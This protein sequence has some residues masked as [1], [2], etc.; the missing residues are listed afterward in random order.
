MD[1][2]L[3]AQEL[4]QAAARGDSEAVRRLLESGADP[5]A[6]NAFGRTPIQV[7]MMGNPQVAKL[8]LQAG[9]NPNMPDRTTGSLPAHDAARQGFLDT[10]KV[11]HH[12]GARFDLP[13]RWGHHPL[14]LA[15]ESGHSQ[16]VW[17]LQEQLG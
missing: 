3:G 14:D 2:S 4:C 9:A 15:R 6:E 13:D 10:L 12:W 8:L 11:L 1:A 16:V 7:M 17:Y 5:N